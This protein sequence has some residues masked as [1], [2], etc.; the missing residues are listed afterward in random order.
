MKCNCSNC[1]YA[2]SI[3]NDG[4]QQCLRRTPKLIIIE[5]KN[6]YKECPCHHLRE[7][8]HSDDGLFTPSLE[9]RLMLRLFK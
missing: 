2:G 9:T 1:V 3:L 5:K 4:D 6:I 7:T 8:E